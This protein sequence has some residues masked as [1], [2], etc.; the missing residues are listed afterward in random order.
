MTTVGAA[1]SLE[2]AAGTRPLWSDPGWMPMSANRL[3]VACLMSSLVS[4][5]L[6]VW[7]A[8]SPHDHWIVPAPKTRAPL[9]AR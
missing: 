2:A 7:N 6:N 1:A 4:T 5:G 3:T 9:S 8:S